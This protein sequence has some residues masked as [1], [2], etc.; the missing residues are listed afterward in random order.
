MKDLILRNE[1]YIAQYEPRKIMKKRLVLRDEQDK[2]R[3]VAKDPCQ[4]HIKCFS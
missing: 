1:P 3:V 2:T 4:E